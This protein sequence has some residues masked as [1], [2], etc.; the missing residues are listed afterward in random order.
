[1]QVDVKWKVHALKTLDCMMQGSK[2]ARLLPHVTLI[3]ETLSDDA[4]CA[5][6]QPLVR[7]HLLDATHT[8]IKGQEAQEGHKGHKG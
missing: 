5:S 2:T 7:A 1:V 6:E 4:L 3:V 8:L